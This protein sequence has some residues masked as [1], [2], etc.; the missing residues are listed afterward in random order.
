MTP[1][2]AEPRQMADRQVSPRRVFMASAVGS[3]IEFYD[4][5]I[6]GTAAHSFSRPSSSRISAIPWRSSPPSPPSARHSWPGPSVPPC[7]ATMETASAAKAPW[8]SR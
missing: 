1:S 8:W 7:S 5:Y 6:Y 4:F 3:A 2:P